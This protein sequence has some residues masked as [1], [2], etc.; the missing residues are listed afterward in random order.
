LIFHWVS[1]FISIQ[2]GLKDLRK[3]TASQIVCPGHLLA[4]WA[5]N[6]H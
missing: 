4:S 5:S 6:D 2:G 3:A 1:F